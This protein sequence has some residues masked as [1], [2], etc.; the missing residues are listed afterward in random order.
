MITLF[1]FSRK[2]Q[3]EAIMEA[4]TEFTGHVV[5]Q[6]THAL[7]KWKFDY[8]RALYLGADQK[9]HGLWEQDSIW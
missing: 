8:S 4:Y 6:G 3:R 9:T 2:S 7:L 1:H 5:D